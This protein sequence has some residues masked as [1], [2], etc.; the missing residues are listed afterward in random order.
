MVGPDMIDPVEATVMFSGP[1]VTDS[2]LVVSAADALS[3]LLRDM[4]A[5][6]TSR[7]M[8]TPPPIFQVLLLILFL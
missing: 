1:T 2:S 3:L 6:S 8:S 5:N 7:A 4:I